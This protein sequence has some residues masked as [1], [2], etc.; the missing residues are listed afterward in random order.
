MIGFARVYSMEKATKIS[1]IGLGLALGCAWAIGILLVGIIALV[2]PDFAVDPFR[3][4]FNIF[5]PGWGK[6]IGLTLVMTVWSFTHGF[7][8]GFLIGIFY[9]WFEKSF[10]FFFNFFVFIKFSH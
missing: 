7:V 3:D 9:I 5:Y 6:S 8:G 10:V 1:T 4:M 2:A